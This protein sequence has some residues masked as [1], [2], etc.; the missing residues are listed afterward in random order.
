MSSL[1]LALMSLAIFIRLFDPLEKI[2]NWTLSLAPGTFALNLWLAP[3]VTIYVKIYIFN[4]TNPNEFLAGKQKL[5]VQE[6]GPYVYTE[7]LEN[8]NPIFHSNGTLSYVPRRKVNHVPELSV[9]NPKLEKI[10]VPNIP[11]LGLASMVSD[12]SI[13]TNLAFLTLTKYLGSQ[14]FLNLTV[15]DY[16]WGYDDPLVKM[17]NKIV[18]TK[19]PFSKFGLLDRMYDEGDNVITI[20]LFDNGLKMTDKGYLPQYSIDTWNGSPGLKTWGYKAEDFNSECKLIRGASD[21]VIFPRN[22]SPKI[23]PQIFRKNFCRMIP[24]VFVKEGIAKNGIPAYWYKLPED[25]FDTPEVNPAQA[26]YCNPNTTKCLPKGLSD[27][28]P[29][30]YNIPAAVSF[31]HF[32]SGDPKLLEDVE[33]LSP[34]IQQHGTNIML[35]P[36]LGMPMEFQTRIQTNI[37]MKKIRYNSKITHFSNL[38]LPIVWIGLVSI[39]FPFLAMIFFCLSPDTFSFCPTGIGRFTELHNIPFIFNRF[40]RAGFDDSNRRY[41]F[42]IRYFPIYL[43][44]F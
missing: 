38:T 8:T 31:P 20:R 16:L 39:K 21:G 4:F 5:K 23:I 30:Y 15:H 41:F 28:T 10:I 43:F 11:Y 36:N 34:N 25:V 1:G 42:H 40:R 35:Q 19:I 13:F 6:L 33:G 3:P 17:A 29:C 44:F 24:L 9:G 22:M 12:S 37:V 27:I 14:P 2:L 26:C 18:S 7:Q 32:L